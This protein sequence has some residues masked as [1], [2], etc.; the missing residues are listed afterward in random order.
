MDYNRPL[1]VENVYNL[2]LTSNR[3]RQTAVCMR[4]AVNAK[5]NTR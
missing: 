1:A 5:S 2:P 3:K 4:F